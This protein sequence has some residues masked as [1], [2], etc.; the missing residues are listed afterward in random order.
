[1]LLRQ[2]ARQGTRIEMRRFSAFLL[3]V[4]VSIISVFL[5]I[6]LLELS[7]AIFFPVPF[8]IEQNMYFGPDP[9]T[10]YRLKANS[11]GS[12]R[13][14]KVPA[15][16]NRHGHRSD[17]VPLVKGKNVFRILVLGDS[18]TVG[19]GVEQ[20][21]TYSSQ[22]QRLLN[23]NSTRKIEVIN[24]G[25]GGWNPF[26]YAQYYEY[27]GRWFDPDIVILG[28]FVGN[29]ILNIDKGFRN[30]AIL[31]RRVSR[32]KAAGQLVMLKVWL[33][34]HSHLARLVMRRPNDVESEGSDCDDF[35]DFILSLMRERETNYREDFPEIRNK[36]ERAIWQLL[37]IKKRTDEQGIPLLVVVIPDETQIN[38]ALRKLVFTNSHDYDVDMPQS[39]LKEWFDREGIQAL[40]LL[41]TFRAD[42]RCLY[43]NT[44]WT[45]EGHRLA[46]ERILGQVCATAAACPRVLVQ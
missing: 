21:D 38:S 37:R 2:G 36:A 31:G 8:S 16:T 19:A 44:H 1:V 41:P 18:F 7:L 25:V 4:S 11:I 20:Q 3:N 13:G 40:D 34:V 24:T 14:G 22:L 29:D 28:F 10:G 46:A 32:E 43:R 15:S 42:D 39:L 35:P 27:Y 30:T 6:S 5:T 26:E 9:Y 23:Q 17:D 12:F 33:H 45:P